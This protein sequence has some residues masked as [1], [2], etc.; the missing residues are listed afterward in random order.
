MNV[1]LDT[2][3][4]VDFLAERQPF[5]SASARIMTKAIDKQF[6][7]GISALSIVNVHYVCHDKC[8][9][10]SDILKCKLSLIKGVTEVPSL[11]SE[12]IL[13]AYSSDWDDFEDCVQNNIAIR[14]N[15]DYIVTRNPQDFQLSELKVMTPEDF[16]AYI[17]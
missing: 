16:L 1:F 17:N 15:A 2:N 8:K 11:L 9:I 10:P 7:L 3:V 13:S 14:W 12:D 6:K 5:Y 4:C